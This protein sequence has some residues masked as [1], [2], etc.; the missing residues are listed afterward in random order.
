[1]TTRF[2]FNVDVDEVPVA[3]AVGTTVG[4]FVGA[5]LYSLAMWYWQ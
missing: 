3:L 1:M 4:F 2:R 5:C